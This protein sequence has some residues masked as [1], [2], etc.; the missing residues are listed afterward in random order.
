V[1]STSTVDV[2]ARTKVNACGSWWY[3]V[4]DK[5]LY[6]ATNVSVVVYGQTK[7]VAS[8]I[9]A[10]G[11]RIC[12]DAAG[13]IKV[14]AAADLACGKALSASGADGDVID[15]FYIPQVFPVLA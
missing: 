3:A 14:A 5:P 1:K 15:I 11:A 7:A 6:T 2:L 4:P 10:K 12:P 8:G 13:K 9:I